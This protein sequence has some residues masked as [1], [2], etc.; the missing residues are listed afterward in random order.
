MLVALLL[1]S[2]SVIL[3][4]II[5]V[6]IYSVVLFYHYAFMSVSI[7]MFG[8][9]LGAILISLSDSSSSEDIPQSDMGFL[10]MAMGLTQAAVITV[11]LA[12]PVEFK[13]GAASIGYL[14]RTFFL[15][16]F[17]FVPAGAFITIALTRHPRTGVAYAYDLF[18][19][20]LAC[21]LVPFLL[22]AF[23]GPGAVM[24]TAV[25]PCLAGA[26]LFAGINRRMAVLS[27]GFAV[28]LALFAVFNVS[29]QWLKIRWWHDGRLPAPIYEKW[30]SF[31]RI[32]VN[33]TSL[34][35]RGWGINAQV[36]QSLDD[37]EQLSLKIDSGAETV[38]TRFT[39]DVS[40]IRH[41]KYDIT[42]L[43][44]YVRPAADVFVIGVGGGRDILTGVAFNQKSFTGVEV[45]PL[46]VRTL[47]ERFADFAG[48]LHERPDVRIMAEEGRSFLERNPQQYDII[49]ASLVDTVAATA[50]GAF[51]F[52]ENGLYTREAWKLFLNRLKP[53]GVLTFSRWYYG[54]TNWP[55][56]IY[57]LFALASAALKE[58]GVEDPAGHILLARTKGIDN[59][60][61]IGTILISPSPF[62]P[63]DVR[64]L[65]AACKEIN[66]EIAFSKDISLDEPFKVIL[67]A[68]SDTALNALF[69]LDI[70]P[71]TDD[72]PFFFFH[73][74]WS[75]F[76]GNEGDR[77]GGSSFNLL[78]VRHL[79][80]LLLTSIVLG[81]A[82]IFLPFFK[83]GAMVI[84]KTFKGRQALVER[85][86]FFSLIGLSFMLVEI[87]L[88]QRFSLFLGHPIYGFTVVL[89]GLF[90]STAAG[91]AVSSRILKGPSN[92]ADAVKFFGY[93]FCFL[94]VE[95]V[96]HYFTAHFLG[97]STLLRM[98]SAFVIISFSGFFMGQWFPYGM[99]QIRTQNDGNAAW[100]WA[101][102]GALSI[103]GSVLAMIIS[104]HAGIRV[105]ILMGVAL[106]ALAAA[107]IYVW[108]PVNIPGVPRK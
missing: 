69:P 82:L 72:R 80:V 101:I 108:K 49:Q 87:G 43:V 9:T 22:F 99:R 94:L 59:M 21:L 103:V 2:L 29:G 39:G 98:V 52:T 102:N 10:A 86:L 27:G 11:Q 91:S 35:P 66:C 73:A 57:R 17:P 105:V 107:I 97:A 58:R 6:R 16:S 50:A 79:L 100:Y 7:A 63:E 67:A 76:L 54:S 104:L 24:A 4:E 64:R 33:P 74:R 14:I 70:T 8:L 53:S 1:V 13:D 19:A 20:G 38:I 23:G 32:M 90:L 92:K 71:P 106:Y 44:H 34:R 45:N 15:S 62:S 46:I 89:F 26:L 41:L 47:T 25:F 60:E 85:S 93:V 56:E 5:L 78:A 81:A 84:E 18:G 77:F 83:P 3:W 37:V 42:A 12:L 88:I 95:L 51:A 40:K 31:S 96:S 55:V 28:A 36:G 61:G 75:N 48:R 65:K 68:P 30:N